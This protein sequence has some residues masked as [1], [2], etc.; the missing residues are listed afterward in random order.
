MNC[1]CKNC[2]KE[3]KE[4]YDEF[5]YKNNSGFCRHC[6]DYNKSGGIIDMCGWRTDNCRCDSTEIVGFPTINS[7]NEFKIIN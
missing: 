1:L 2:N 4:S 5:S 6:H 3:I 7:G